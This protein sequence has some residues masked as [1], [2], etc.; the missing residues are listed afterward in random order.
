[1]GK[2]YS[3]APLPL[4]PSSF[5]YLSP[6]SLS[7]P[8]LNADLKKIGKRHGSGTM[9]WGYKHQSSPRP[10]PILRHHPPLTPHPLPPLVRAD[11][12]PPPPLPHTFPPLHARTG[13]RRREHEKRGKYD[14]M[15]RNGHR[16]VYGAVVYASGRSYKGYW[17]LGIYPPLSLFFPF[18][19]LFFLLYSSSSLLASFLF[20][21]WWLVGGLQR[22]Q[23][24]G[25]YLFLFF[26]LIFFF[27][28]F[29]LFLF[30]P[31]FCSSPLPLLVWLAC[32]SVGDH[33]I[34]SGN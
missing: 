31:S 5:L 8:L 12:F 4:Y 6:S 24:S 22:T 3:S 1:M 28:H 21:K 11:E 34:G 15:W 14:G 27:I 29:F 30:H 32:M 16:A 19:F 25:Y 9:W 2:R 23:E 20:G 26:P 7:L 18:I 13:Y 33:T 10:P 17:K